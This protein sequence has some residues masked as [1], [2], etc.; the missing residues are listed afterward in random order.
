M[1]RNRSTGLLRSPG[2]PQ[3][4]AFLELFFDLAFVFALT[5]LSHGLIED[6]SW[7]GAFQTLVLLLAVWWVWSLTATIT[8]RLNPQRSAVQRLVI[9]TM[10]GSLVMAVAVP[11]AFGDTGLIFAGAYVAI[12]VGRGGTL[13]IILPWG[14][15]TGGSSD[16]PSG[17]GT[18]AGRAVGSGTGPAMA[19]R[20]PG[21][22]E[23]VMPP[24]SLAV[25]GLPG[26]APTA[27]RSG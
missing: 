16:A 7:S 1:T 5:Q 2:D 14:R 3:R 6:I 8:D 20:F 27:A 11:D 25:G 24:P 26:D 9:A 13:L 23:A 21:P 17:S 10:V 19:L 12:Q 15:R 22:G 18:C 4:P